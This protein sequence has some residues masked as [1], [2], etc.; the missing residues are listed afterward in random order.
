MDWQ[1]GVTAGPAQQYTACLDVLVLL[2]LQMFNLRF[3][4][5][6]TRTSFS[7]LFMAA[8]MN[9]KQS[10]PMGSPWLPC[11]LLSA[12]LEPLPCVGVQCFWWCKPNRHL[13]S[14]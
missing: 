5:L 8:N 6:H 3:Q 10:K 13:C 12:Q 1:G 2:L 7:T 11:L 14:N 4:C 9:A